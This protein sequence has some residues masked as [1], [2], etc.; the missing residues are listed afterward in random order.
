M[1][2]SVPTVDRWVGE[3]MP[4]ETWGLRARRFRPSV[5]MSWAHARAERHPELPDDTPHGPTEEQR[6][7]AR[8][9]LE[10]ARGQRPGPAAPPTPDIG[11]DPDIGMDLGM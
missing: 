4:S 5:A 1:G 7:A 10:R 8:K 6:R 3:G 2:V 9:V 11:L